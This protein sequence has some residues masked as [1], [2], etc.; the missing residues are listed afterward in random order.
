MRVWMLAP[1]VIGSLPVLVAADSSADGV[2]T[3]VFG[4]GIEPSSSAWMADMRSSQRSSATRSH[5][6]FHPP[7]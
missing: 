6:F 1:L 2:P 7:T 4:R 3:R 5:R